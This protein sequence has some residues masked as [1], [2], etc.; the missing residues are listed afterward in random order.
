MK[1]IWIF[2]VFSAPPEYEMRYRT[3]KMA[4]E[5][6][7][8]GDKVT[9]FASSAIH[10][11]DINLIEDKAPYIVK[12]YRGIDYVFVRCSSYHTNGADRVLSLVQFYFRLRKVIRGFDKPDCIIA[13]SPYP[14]VAHSGILAARKFRVPCISEI[15]DLWP[16]SII[17]YQGQSLRNPI[18]LGLL[19][20]EKWIYRHSDA[21]VF[22]MPG[23]KDYIHEKK[24]D[25][26]IDM[27]HIHHINNGVDIEEFDS[28]VKQHIYTDSD[29]QNLANFKLTYCGSI[30]QANNLQ[31]VIKGAECLLSRGD[32]RARF[33]L[34]GDGGHRPLL[35]QYCAEHGIHTVVFKGFVEKKYIPSIIAQTDINILSYEQVQAWHYGGSQN[36]L[37]EYLASGK[38]I[39]STIQMSYNPIEEYSCGVVLDEQSPERFADAVQEFLDMGAE[40]RAV[41]G[42]RAR[43]LSHRYDYPYL[44]AQLKG[45]ISGLFGSDAPVKLISL[46][47]IA[48]NEEKTIGGLLENIVAQD[49]PHERI[50]LLLVDSASTDGTKKLFEEFALKE[51]SF[52]GIRILDNPARFLPHGCN[53]ALRAYAGDVLIRIDAHARVPVDFARRNVEVLEGGEY[54][55]GGIRPTV[56]Q[57]STPWG[58]TLLLAENSIFGSS[59]AAYRRGQE[60][61]IVNSIFHGAYRRE[62]FDKVGQYDERLLRTEDNDMSYRIR[63]AG[64]RFVRDPAIY[65]EQFVRSSLRRML[66]QKKANGYWIGRTLF[67]SPFCLRIHHLVPAL[68]LFIV[69]ALIITG[70]AFSWIPLLVAVCLYAGADVLITLFSAIRSPKRNMTML[71]LPLVFVLMHVVYG[72][73]TVQGVLRGLLDVLLSRGR[74]PDADTPLA[75][76]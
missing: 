65:S 52:A 6:V 38:P 42:T 35:E 72:L 69:L 46:V 75:G 55:C 47:V 50:E 57:E 67:I 66:K 15:R 45:I 4:Q 20:L 74:K 56:L 9:I 54:V 37:F 21:V 11:T 24:W 34:F 5:L 32:D 76:E 13:E 33:I 31:L 16:E 63:K 48:Y 23:G 59:P 3:S 41:M 53:V 60:R 19:V 29:L 49:Y 7:K 25:K 18:I 2:S 61:N 58:E 22:T 8:G 44:A 39:L 12:T 62:V 14:T 64:F 1:N 51:S 71:A 26:V 73:G 40:S 43:E 70:L 27:S 28:D 10:N 30:R 36:K 17:D 68:A